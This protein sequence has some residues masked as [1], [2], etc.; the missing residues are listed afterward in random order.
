MIVVRRQIGE[1][2]TDHFNLHDLA[3]F[4]KKIHHGGTE[5]VGGLFFSLSVSV[6][7]CES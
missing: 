3:S 2:S 4:L 5:R 6:P 7:P 1:R